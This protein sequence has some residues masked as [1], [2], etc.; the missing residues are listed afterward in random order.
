MVLT[1]LVGFVVHLEAAWTAGN[2]S[3]D[4]T[5]FSVVIMPCRF[6]GPVFTLLTDGPHTFETQ[7]VPKSRSN[8]IVTFKFLMSGPETRSIKVFAECSSGSLI[9]LGQGGTD[10]VINNDVKFSSLY[11]SKCLEVLPFVQEANSTFE[12]F[13]VVFEG[14]ASG[15]EP[16]QIK[17]ITFRPAD[18]V[19]SSACSK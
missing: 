6:I 7:I 14:T 4:R 17:D 15:I 10:F 16:I 2:L 5:F 11:I 8:A 12:Y 9:S 3:T 1:L 18:V 13:K 19:G